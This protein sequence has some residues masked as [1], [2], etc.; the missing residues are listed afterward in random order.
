MTIKQNLTF[1]I[2]CEFI[3]HN[4]KQTLDFAENFAKIIKPGDFIAFFGTLGVGK[5]LFI[6]GLCRGLGFAGDV[7]SPTFSIMHEYKFCEKN[8]NLANQK[9][10]IH[11]DMYRITSEDDLISIGFFDYV[12]NSNIII[13]EWSENII[14]FLPKKYYKINLNFVNEFERSIKITKEGY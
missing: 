2:P 11:C 10:I 14:K 7:Y 1:K 5:T 6:K 12:N 9:L 4:P 8:T 3:S 13:T